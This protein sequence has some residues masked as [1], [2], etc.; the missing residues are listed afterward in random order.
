[1][2][3]TTTNQAQKK[4][5]QNE[6]DSIL[7][8]AR[9][10]SDSESKKVA[11]ADIQR[12]ADQLADSI[13][14]FVNRLS[15]GKRK[16]K[17]QF[18]EILD[19]GT[20]AQV[21]KDRLGNLLRDAFHRKGVSDSYIRRIMPPELRV[22]SH[23]NVRYL[24]DSNSGPIANNSYARLLPKNEKLN[25]AKNTLERQIN[26]KMQNPYEKTN[27]TPQVIYPVEENISSPQD[28]ET[29]TQGVNPL[30]EEIKN[31]KHELVIKAKQIQRYEIDLENVKRELKEAKHFMK[32]DTFIAR[33]YLTLGNSDIPIRIVVNIPNKEIESA[34]IDNDALKKAMMR[35]TR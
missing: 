31:L 30:E 8:L 18:Q 20:R 29:I 17:E 1:M 13:Y 7:A 2:I 26:Q 16:I 15:E 3:N 9:T 32:E 10:V 22:S 23:A 25:D 6:S 21:P 35:T 24:P 11:E 12:R 4:D 28:Q 34:E 27:L 33:T 19:I 14:K 5:K